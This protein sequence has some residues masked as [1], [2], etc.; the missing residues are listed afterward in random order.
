MTI[1]TSPYLCNSLLSDLEIRVIDVISYQ[2][3]QYSGT[4]WENLATGLAFNMQTPMRDKVRLI[5][6]E[7]DRID[8]QC[9]TL[10]EKL[11]V[12]I[13]TFV[14][15]CKMYGANLNLID[16]LIEVLGSERVFY[17]PYRILIETILHERLIN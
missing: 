5:Q 17:T 13:N 1:Y 11:Y 14:L 15:R 4:D 2:F 3:R 8:R 16:H 9:D 12:L 7:V 6:G 10:H